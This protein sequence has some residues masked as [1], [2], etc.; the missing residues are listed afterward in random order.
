MK[1]LITAEDVL[2]EL[3]KMADPEKVISKE[4]KFGITTSNSLGIYI[5]DLKTLAKQV[6][7]SDELAFELFE[8]DVYE[9]KVLIPFFFNPKS[10]TPELIE[11]WI[12]S[13]NT[14]EICDTYCMSFIGQSQ[15]AYDKIFDYVNHKNEFQKRAGFVLMVGH[16]FGHKN[17]PNTDF[18]AFLP[19]IKSQATD[20]RNFVKK[21]V[22]W[23]LRTIGKRNKDLNKLALTTAHEILTLDS[24]SAQ[25]IAKD[26]IKELESPKVNIQ[27]YPRS[28]Y[29]PK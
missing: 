28:I 19:I 6:K 23:A 18:E 3:K 16:H 2:S 9:A 15:Y 27:D 22:N 25:W 17:A 12:A 21:A 10:I 5:K 26:A 11:Q 4:K 1:K 29:R 8:S 14:W 7:K 20:E 24:K 13:F